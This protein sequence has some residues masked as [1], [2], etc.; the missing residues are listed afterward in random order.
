EANDLGLPQLGGEAADLVQMDQP[1]VNRIPPGITTQLQLPLRMVLAVAAGLG[2]ALLV[3]YLDPTVRGR[4][5]VEAMGL[6]VM[7]EIPKK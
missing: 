4:R 3:D 7:A 2:L 6:A 5:E 1:I